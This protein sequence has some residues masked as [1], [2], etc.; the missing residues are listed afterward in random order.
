MSPDNPITKPRPGRP[1]GPEQLA[2]VAEVADAM[3]VPIKTVYRWTREM[4]RDGK[5]LLPTKKLGSLVRIRVSDLGEKLEQRMKLRVRSD[6]AL[7][8]FSAK[9][10]NAGGEE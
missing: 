9:A 6:P 8:F 4:C 1:A 7:S 5:P 2:T 10:D 3:R